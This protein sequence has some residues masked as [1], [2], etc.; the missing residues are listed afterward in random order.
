[1]PTLGEVIAQFDAW[2][3]PTLAEDWDAVGLLTG[4][5]ADTVTHVAFAVDITDETVQW[6][7]AQGAQL[8]FTHHPLY[9]RGTTSIDGDSPKGR[10]VHH[11]IANYLAIHVA[12][13]NADTARPGV[14]D[15]IAHAL[16]LQDL[17]PIRPHHTDPRLGLGRVG[18]MAEPCDFAMFVQ[19][20]FEA[21]PASGAGI[22]WSG[23]PGRHITTVAVCGGAGDDLLG[24]IDAD[25]YVTSDLRHHVAG[26]YL[27]TGRASLIDVPHAA[28]ES[29]FLQPLAQGVERAFPGVR[30]SVYPAITDPWTGHSA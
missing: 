29:L 23:D 8:L 25:V 20:V 7:I 27:A 30:T 24:E 13:T 14:S 4:R 3:P 16:H 6:A 11:A 22:K 17:R 9:L 21:M 5:R 1:M 19:R 15:A 26:E 28:A 18:R 10:L 12:H 2:F